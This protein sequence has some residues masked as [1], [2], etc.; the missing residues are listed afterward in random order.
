MTDHGTNPALLN[1]S[2]GVPIAYRVHGADRALPFVGLVHSLAMDHR[3]WNPVAERL[4]GRANVIAIDAR[5]H[6]RSGVSN[7]PY[8]ADRMAQ[9]LLEV[10]DHLQVDKAVVGGAS[11]GG[12]IALTFAGKHQDRTSGLALID[13]TAWYGPTAPKDWEDRAMKAVSQ[14]LGALVGFQKSR[15]FSDAFCAREPGV[16]QNCVDTFLANDLNAYVS[17]C[18]MLGVFDGRTLLPQIRVP[19]RILVGDEDYAAPIEMA[20]ALH[21]GIRHSSLTVIPG[22]RHLTPLEVPD[23]IAGALDELCLESRNDAI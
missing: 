20:Q 4:A 5:G 8:T 6:G 10:M 16:V 12:C 22:A 17:T 18:R 14:G 19:T 2:D 1:A 21:A 9:D 11:M 7:P 15:W 3:F 23:I 13:T